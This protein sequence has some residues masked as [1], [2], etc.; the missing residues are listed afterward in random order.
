MRSCIASQPIFNIKKDVFGYELLYRASEDSLK[1]DASDG[2]AATKDVILTAFTNIGI[3]KITGGRRAFLNFTSDLILDEVPQMLSNDLLVVELLEDIRPS[4]QIMDACRRLKRKGY[5]IALDDFV[6]TPETEQ[7][8]SIA[9]IIKVDF[10]SNSE[11]DI[12]LLIG[13]INKKRRKIFLAE[14]VETDEDFTLA[15]SLGFTL[16]Q[17][18]FFCRPTISKVKS[19][20]AMKASR[21]QLIRIASNPDINF[22]DLADVIRRDIVL[23]FRLLKIV[24]SAYYGLRYSVKG[25]RHALV[26]LGLKDLKKWLALIL[27][28]EAIGDKP[29]EL[30]R[31]ALARGI[32]M[33]K[34]ALY[35]KD[36]KSR[37]EYFLT[38]LFSLSDAVL[39]ADLESILE[40]THLSS[41]ICDPLITG[42]GERAELLKIIYHLER[43]EWDEAEEMAL[44]H[45]VSQETAGELYLQALSEAN[46]LMD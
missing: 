26:I 11:K 27:L 12:R 43:A 38:G 4:K 29:S 30:I 40:E 6:C 17:G 25:I 24:N 36:K 1:Y 3:E 37:D 16:F 21:L 46:W 31:T 20:D 44:K 39:D 28:H 19:V 13:R 23:S 22:Q 7:L 42:Q 41:E 15:V 35:R 18:F 2:S 10:K 45:G 5:M 9:D 34:L 33:E 8:I 32:F 14:K